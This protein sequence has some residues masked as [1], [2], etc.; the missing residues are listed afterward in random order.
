MHDYINRQ[1][2]A[3]ARAWEQA[4]SLLDHAS[5]EGRDL[6]ATEQEQYDRIN[7]DLD[8]RTAIIEKL[9][10]DMDR[11]ARAAEIRVP[12]AT[13]APAS[14]DADLLR[15]L[16]R[17]EV[18]SVTFEKRQM[19]T[20]NNS[21]TVPQGFYDVL[22]E[23]LRYTGPWGNEA[24]GYTILTTASGEDIKVP[25][26][27]AYSAATATAE[28]A[29][30]GISNPTT[31]FLTLRA[32]KFGTL[33]TVSRE[34][35]E[36]SGIDLVSFIGRQA[37]N[38]VG[39]I[40]NEK[41]AVGTGTL[42]PQGLFTAAGSGVRG[43]AT[44]FAFSAD[45]L[46]DLVHSVDSAYASRPTAG[47]Q[48]R[49]ATLSTLRK[50]KDG[51]GQFIYNPTLGTQALLLGYPVYENPFAPAIG[52]AAK[53]VVFGDMSS[54]HVRQVGGVEVARSDDAYFANDLVAFRISIRVDGAL[55]QASA[56]KFYQGK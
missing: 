3:R 25:T 43:T 19:T 5:A 9:Q 53:S 28:A 46:I 50:L 13:V 22:Q 16:V 6:T 47:F 23:Q 20:A 38:A 2:E 11:E 30:F 45:D 10:K 17:G 33:I 55:G 32:H 31:S 51:D 56:V 42:E 27:T 40:V 34:L 36:D 14:S 37:G 52:T 18:R 49:R 48:M 8:E 1:V 7:S 15:S 44:D 41:L 54:F 35:L 12:E 39:N 29:V 4:K 24:V 26:Q 21:G